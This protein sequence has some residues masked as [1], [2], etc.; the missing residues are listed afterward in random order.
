MAAVHRAGGDEMAALVGGKRDGAPLARHRR[1]L[2]VLTHL[3]ALALAVDLEGRGF[4]IGLDQ[5]HP[6]GRAL[7]Y[8]ERMRRPAIDHDHGLAREQAD[9]VDVGRAGG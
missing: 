7:S 4:R 1:G 2:E 9:H 3:E 5:Q 6:F 8:G